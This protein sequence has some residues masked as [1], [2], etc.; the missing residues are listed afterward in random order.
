MRITGGTARGRTLRAPRGGQ[1]RPTSDKVRAAIYNVLAAR[2]ELAGQRVL[3]LFAGSGA[4]GLEALSRGADWVMFLDASASACR[5]IRSNLDQI[6]F[7]ERAEVRQ[8]TLPGD[9]DRCPGPT[10]RFA[11]ALIDPPY[12]RGLGERALR[13]LAA[14]ELLA[15]EAWIVV[16]DRRGQE[17]PVQCGRFVRE[18]LRRYGDTE[19]SLYVGG[20]SV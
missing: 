12:G 15:P 6:G 19:I 1:I 5:L 14:S 2:Y 11:G 16:E 10:Q 3:D 7:S 17:I 9:L 20:G 8:A 18:A 13:S 4:L